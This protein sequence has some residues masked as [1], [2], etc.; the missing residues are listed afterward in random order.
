MLA[1]EQ[2]TVRA[3]YDD[4]FLYLGF[5]CK[6]SCLDPVYNQ[7]NAF[8]A[9]HKKH[10]SPVWKD[11]SIEIFLMPQSNTDYFHVVINSLGTIYDSISSNKPDIWDSKI[12]SKGKAHNG[13]WTLELKMP[14]KSLSIAAPSENSVWRVIFC[15]SNQSLKELSSWAPL[16]STFHEIEKTGTLTFIKETPSVSDI[17]FP[18]P[19]SRLDL[20]GASVKNVFNSN[21]KIEARL[22]IS[23]GDKKIFYD[24]TYDLRPEEKASISLKNLFKHADL[25]RKITKES[26]SSFIYSMSIFSGKTLCY[27]TPGLT[28]KNIVSLP[29]QSSLGYMGVGDHMENTF[30]PI[31]ELCINNGSAE[32]IALFFKGAKVLKNDKIKIRIDMPEYCS[33][34]RS[35][36]NRPLNAPL[37]IRE[38]QMGNDGMRHKRYELTFPGSL[39]L[40][41]TD[42]SFKMRPI[43]LI[44]SADAP[45][46][47]VASLSWQASINNKP[48]IGKAQKIKLR[49]IS[50]LVGK[51]AKDLPLM[52]WLSQLPKITMLS[53]K[54]KEQLLAKYATSG[55]NLTNSIRSIGRTENKYL[56]K[57]FFCAL[58]R[59][60][61]DTRNNRPPCAVKGN[62]A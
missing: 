22:N 55:F 28:G 18:P 35:M 9:S 14:F 54:E 51:T 34:E 53:L 62:P 4:N 50:P 23:F 58:F 2:T 49:I 45:N 1:S 57:R 40:D 41:S 59:S 26:S 36:V 30:I 25:K 29:I 44:I 8:K 47:K 16:G 60:E 13:F 3:I 56:K 24:K 7:L 42:P 43:G 37:A 10:D 5:K 17:E 6:Q 11:D 31:K 32:R 33:L 21:K 46:E 52:F 61:A 38:M 20:V 12:I 19:P 15:R 48:L 39:M 27:R